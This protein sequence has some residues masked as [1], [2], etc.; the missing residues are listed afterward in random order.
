MFIYWVVQGSSFTAICLD[1][2][3]ILWGIALEIVPLIFIAYTEWGNLVFGTLPVAPEV[4]LFVLPFAL[5]MLLLEEL[6]KF[7]VSRIGNRPMIL[8]GT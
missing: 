5:L 8:E 1:N 7:I 3:I 6:R 4:W 2:H